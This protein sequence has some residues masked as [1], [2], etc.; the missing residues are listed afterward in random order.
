MKH[1]FIVT[2]AN[3][4][5]GNN[6]VRQ[7]CQNSENE[8]RTLVVKG[9][10]EASL[11]GL[12][13]KIYYGD[14]TNPA[15]LREI[16]DNTDGATVYVI[17]CAAIVSIKSKYD[18]HMRDVNITGTLNVANMVLEKG[19]RFIYVSSVHAITERPNG[20]PM[21]EISVFEPDKVKGLYAKTKAEAASKI[22]KMVSEKG[23]DACILHPSGIIGPGDFAHSHLTQ[24]IIDY[25]EKRLTAAVNGGYDFVDV[26][27][28]ANGVIS[29]C[30]HGKCGECYILSNKYITVK[31]MLDMA[32]Q[33]YGVRKI[34]T[35]LPL[36]FAKLTAPLSELYYAIKK[37][38][39]LYTSY[40]LYTLQSNSNFSNAK[41]KKELSYTTRNFF[42]TIKDTIE[43]LVAH[44][45]LPQKA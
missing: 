1:I 3:G 33:V 22:L 43:W 27:D 10:D 38:P 4:F 12:N 28:V 8:I 36:W 41:A 9:T 30:Y 13:C 2:G 29:A 35:I 17:H 45:R 37:Q 32:S 21:S 5:L 26:R 24:L 14:V 11:T 34:K 15:S 23:L 16:F 42:D 20:Q 31:E 25:C 19:A 44:K 39:P 6:I 7:L 18:K 40:S